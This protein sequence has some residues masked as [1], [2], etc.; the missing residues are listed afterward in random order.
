MRD[1]IARRDAAGKPPAP[2]LERLLGSL[3]LADLRF[4]AAEHHLDRATS[5]R[6]DIARWWRELA[7][8]RAAS[9]HCEAAIPAYDRALRL[10][11]ATAARGAHRTDPLTIARTRLDKAR[12]ARA[13]A[14][15]DLAEAEYRRALK[16]TADISSGPPGGEVAVS[17]THLTLP[18]ICSV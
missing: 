3:L 5:L 10:D 11:E 7:A 12:C 18:T 9:G 13:A 1:Q 2:A 14:Q 6:P 8:A 4:E 16:E 17:Y 15:H